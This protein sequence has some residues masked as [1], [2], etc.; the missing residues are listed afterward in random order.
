VGIDRPGQ[1][2]Q[3]R[4]WEYTTWDELPTWC[5]ELC[6][7]QPPLPSNSAHKPKVGIRTRAPIDKSNGLM[8]PTQR[9]LEF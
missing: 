3:T 5:D 2:V 6:P 9:S 8:S 7:S 1:P 4:W